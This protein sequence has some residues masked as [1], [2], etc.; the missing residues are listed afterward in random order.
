M[1]T[2]KRLI[3]EYL[4]KFKGR[5]FLAVVFMAVVSASSGL[6]AFLVKP[7]L[8][9]IF[10]RKDQATLILIPIALIGIYLARGVSRY[11]SSSIMQSI[12]Q[13]IARDLRDEAFAKLIRLDLSFTQKHKKGKLISRITNDAFIVQ[14]SISI[15]VCDI[16]REALTMVALLIVV[17]YRDWAMALFSILITPIASVLIVRV[18]V[19]LRAIS[20]SAQEKMANLIGALHESLTSVE[21]VQSFRMEKHETERFR[22]ANRAYLQEMIRAIKLNEIASPMLE[23]LGAL[24]IAA[25]I[26]YGG[27]KVIAGE[28]SVGEFFSFMT[29]LFMLYAPISKLSRANNKIQQAIAAAERIFELIDAE[30]KIKERDDPMKIDR[31]RDRIELKNLSLTYDGA[32]SASLKNIDLTIKAGEKIAV[33]GASGAGKSSL[34]RIL[35]RFHDPTEGALHFD[36]FDARDISIDSLRALIGLV[37][38]EITLFAMSVAENIAHGA[39]I[40][41]ERIEAAARAANAHSFIV[42]LPEGYETILLERGVSLSVG[43][44]QRI[45]IARAI[46][47]DPSILIFDEATSALDPES[48]F[49]ARSAIE[50]IIQDKTAIFIA[51]KISTVKTAD[52][53]VLL[54]DGRISAIGSHSELMKSSPL[55]KKLFDSQFADR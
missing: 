51:H 37:P 24:G 3:F 39:S 38:Q 21:V 31:L 44:R 34:T 14:D 40:A 46:V 35:T 15:V 7:I 9:D 23:F 48:E 45:T 43:Q 19:G 12:G 2:Y 18:G 1:K 50:K 26:Y 47:A 20:K 42:D 22:R 4:A 25:I 55:Y 53:I 36:G 17:F 5:F 30:S 11:F 27:S 52:R 41:R 28:S 29:A 10:L 49:I 13:F 6:S 54:E 32:P 16:A 8:D 33:V